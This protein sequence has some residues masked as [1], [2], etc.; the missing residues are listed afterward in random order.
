[1]APWARAQIL[2]TAPGDGWPH[3]VDLLQPNGVQLWCHMLLACLVCFLIG[4]GYASRR[5]WLE[6]TP[7]RA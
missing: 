4:Y 3:A 1:M 7:M 5:S 6:R 2:G